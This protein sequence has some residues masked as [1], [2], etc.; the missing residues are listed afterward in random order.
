MGVGFNRCTT[1]FLMSRILVMPQL[2]PVTSENM[3]YAGPIMGAV[4]LLSGIWYWA[5]GVSHVALVEMMVYNHSPRSSS[6][7]EARIPT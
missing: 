2:H 5:Y 1:E 7:A 6:A 3:N 4:I